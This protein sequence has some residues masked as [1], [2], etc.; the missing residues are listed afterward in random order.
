MSSP[1][2]LAACS[3]YER[4]ALTHAMGELFSAIG[5]APACGERVLIKPNLLRADSTGLT[6]TAP[7]I[8]RAACVYVLDHGAVPQIADSPG[9]GTVAGIARSVGIAAALADLPG[10]PAVRA[11]GSP[12]AVPLSLGGSVPISRQALE[13]DSILNL[14]RLKAHTMMRVTCAVKNLYGCICG[15]RKA[16]MHAVH[17][18]KG[19]R[20]P[21]L[22]LDILGALP[23]VTSLADAITAMHVNGP[24]GGKPFHAGLLVASRS[25]VALDTMVYAMMGLTPDR[26]PLWEEALLREIPGSLPEDVPLLGADIHAFS[27]RDFKTPTTLMGQSFS[28]PRLLKS[29]LKRL[30]SG[31]TA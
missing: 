19:R 5:Y 9:F 23:P 11:L 2:A 4:T 25:P 14:P 17:G 28:P 27:L 26:V 3:G 6:C 10:A 1:V 18:D 15:T 29:A 20:F 12:V 16:L 24:S 13:A 8:V 31:I 7:E 22:I 21:S 30:W